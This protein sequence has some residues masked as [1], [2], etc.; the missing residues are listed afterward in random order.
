[1]ARD[2]KFEIVEHLVT[3]RT[4]DSGWSLELNLVSYNDRPAKYD[5]RE[6]SPDHRSMSKGITLCDEEA[7][8]IS[9]AIAKRYFEQHAEDEL[10]D[11]EQE[12]DAGPTDEAD[13]VPFKKKS[14]PQ[15]AARPKVEAKPKAKTPAKAKKSA[16]SVV[17]PD[18]IQ[19]PF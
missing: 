11:M 8:K 14:A 12:I 4:N 5:I 16:S 15:P 13:I 1:M 2:F 17:V 18:G 9:A 3:L 19:L 6:W 10:P 7:E